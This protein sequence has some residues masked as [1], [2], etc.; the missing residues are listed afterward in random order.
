MVDGQ[1]GYICCDFK[2]ILVVFVGNQDLVNRVEVSL[3]EVRTPQRQRG[4]VYSSRNR[5]RRDMI[6]DN[7]IYQLFV[8]G[9][10]TGCDKL[11]Y[12]MICH[13]DMSMESRGAAEFS[14]QFGKRHWLLDMTYRVQ[15]G[16]PTN[17]RMIDPMELNATQV[18]EYMN[19][20]SKE[21]IE[22]FS[23]PKGLFPACTQVDSSVP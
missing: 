20:S 15:N 10:S 9:S 16:L 22:G 13:R 19:R 1:W 12:C 17:N 14:R 4:R 5:L 6:R 18:E 23:F 21:K 2:H 8:S 3:E 7:P 11:F